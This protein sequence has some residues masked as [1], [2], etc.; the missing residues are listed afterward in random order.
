MIGLRNC[1]LTA[2]A[3]FACVLPSAQCQTEPAS[4]PIAI[5]G[6]ETAITLDFIALMLPEYDGMSNAPPFAPF[7]S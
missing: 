2:A 1:A 7:E 6:K 5:G 4:V 3:V